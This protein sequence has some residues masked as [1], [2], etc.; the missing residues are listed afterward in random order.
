VN[1]QIDVGAASPT[2]NNCPLNETSVP[3]R[4][5]KDHSN[6]IDQIDDDG[7]SAAT[8]SVQSTNCPSNETSVAVATDNLVIHSN[9]IDPID[10]GSKGAVAPTVHSNNCSSNETFVTSATD[11]TKNNV[12]VKTKSKKHKQT[13]N[14][15]LTLRSAKR[16]RKS[17][18]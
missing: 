15:L 5:K 1:N 18:W 8:H 4:S 14:L 9:G 11:N 2:D 16:I 10:D 13:Q 6:E 7:K 3:T 17:R 12:N